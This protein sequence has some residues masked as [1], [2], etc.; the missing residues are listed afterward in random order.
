MIL[1]FFIHSLDE[2]MT[3]YWVLVSDEYFD[4]AIDWQIC[5]FI[6][7]CLLLKRLNFSKKDENKKIIE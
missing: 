5:L 7:I 4:L 6:E 3:K 1:L 2:I